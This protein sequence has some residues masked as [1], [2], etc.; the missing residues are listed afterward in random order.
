MVETTDAAIR[1]AHEAAK[2]S[3]N[4]DP[5]KEALEKW[6]GH[7]GSEYIRERAR[8]VGCSGGG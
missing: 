3:R 8:L 2:T 1:A 5:Q 7:I 4:P 6:E